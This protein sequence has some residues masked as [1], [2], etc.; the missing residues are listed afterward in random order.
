MSSNRKFRLFIY[1]PIVLAFVLCAG[2]LL[3]HMM[4]F[5]QPDQSLILNLNEGNENGRK[6]GNLLEYINEE[7][8]DTVNLDDLTETAIHDLIQ[9]LDPHSA[10]IPAADLETV[11]EP[12]EGKFDGIG[13]EF[14][15]IKDTIVVMGVIP[16]GPSETLGIRTGDRI[17]TI[18]NDTVAGVG[19]KSNDVMSSLRGERGTIVNVG[20]LRKGELGLLD[21]RIKRDKI[22][23][24]SVDAGIMLD[25]HIGYIRISRFAATTLDEFEDHLK[26]LKNEGMKGLILDLR[27]NSGGYLQAAIALADEFLPNKDLIVYTKRRDGQKNT[28]YATRSG[29]WEEQPLVVLINEGSASASEIL[30]GAVQDHDRGQVIGRRSFG[31][32]LVQD[33]VIL[34]DGSGLRLTIA[35]YYTPV[36]R[37]I[38]R[39]YDDLYEYEMD[40]YHRYE[41]GEL[42]SRDSIKVDEDQKF[43]TEAG[44]TVYGGGGIIP[45]VFVPLD[46][47]TSYRFFNEMLGKGILREYALTLSHQFRTKH[48]NADLSTFIT[49]FKIG[50]KERDELTNLAKEAGL[51][52]P[53][54]P[55]SFEVVETEL[56]AHTARNLF[57]GTGYFT[58]QCKD[59]E[60]IGI[61]KKILQQEIAV[62]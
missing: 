5:G 12:L 1:Y 33:Q 59:D 41:T 2:I 55:K 32:G 30:A 21:F 9:Q 57:N 18:E 31:K 48:E 16:G 50:Q 24:Y 49:K 34:P 15:I 37:C 17:V 14:N 54:D 58:I 35:R 39:P 4:Q 3:G 11:N 8:V 36:G 10:Y 42:Y 28:H 19:F 7:Y 29:N 45:D 53:T 22:P 26:T 25:E 44:K 47:N 6:I 60:M 40:T 20:I 27:G 13:V 23:I 52:I 61:A 62:N 43:V 38:Q 56:I 46:T 51:A